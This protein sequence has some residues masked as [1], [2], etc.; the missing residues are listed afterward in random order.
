[1]NGK[2]IWNE[3]ILENANTK[4]KKKWVEQWNSGHEWKLFVDKGVYSLTIIIS[5]SHIYT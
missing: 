2:K 4:N 5:V 3:W 1:M